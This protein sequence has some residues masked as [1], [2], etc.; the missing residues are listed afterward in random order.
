MSW[1]GMWGEAEAKAPEVS[2]VP[3]S[4]ELDTHI[5][6]APEQ[7]LRAVALQRPCLDNLRLRVPSP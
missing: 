1:V 5:P 3:L 6:C 7:R 4:M 2:L